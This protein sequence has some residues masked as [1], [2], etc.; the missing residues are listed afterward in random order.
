MRS[1]PWYPRFQAGQI[2][3]HSDLNQISSFLWDGSNEDRRHLVGFGVVAGLDVTLAGN[4]LTIA[5]GLAIDQLGRT[6]TVPSAQTIALDQTL[7]D[8]DYFLADHAAIEEPNARAL[9]SFT[10]VLQFLQRREQNPPSK[11]DPTLR[12]ARAYPEFRLRL[13]PG[14][15]RAPAQPAVY[16]LAPLTFP[17]GLVLANGVAFASRFY[18][19]RDRL[20]DTFADYGM[21]PSALQKLQRL[22]LVA[23]SSDHFLPAADLAACAVLNDLVYTAWQIGRAEVFASAR[24]PD[25]CSELQARQA[26]REQPVKRDNTGIA[27]GWLLQDSQQRWRWHGEHRSE[28][29]LALNMLGGL[30]DYPCQELV[31]SCLGR[32]EALLDALDQ[33]ACR[34]LRG[35]SGVAEVSRLAPYAYL[36]GTESWMPGVGWSMPRRW[37]NLW[38]LDPLCGALAPPQTVLPRDPLVSTARP[39]TGLR[40]GSRCLS[41]SF[42]FPMNDP[43]YFSAYAEPERNDPSGG[44]LFRLIGLLGRPLEDARGALLQ[45]GLPARCLAEPI[46]DRQAETADSLRYRLLANTTQVLHPILASDRTVRAFAIAETTEPSATPADTATPPA[47]PPR[48]APGLLRRLLFGS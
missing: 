32:A 44:G 40:D 17:D 11:V 37:S 14:R 21:A 48:A 43:F 39:D 3:S 13:V 45:A 9:C 33:L 10:P 38:P 19:L 2:V 4:R 25:L 34:G 7:A 36:G 29:H 15:L 31:R 24:S 20:A 6:I 35:S 27:L 47:S 23:K 42:S 30:R 16:A 28:F 26:S 8:S 12:G 18:E 5:A 1:E 41:P 46:A 22:Q